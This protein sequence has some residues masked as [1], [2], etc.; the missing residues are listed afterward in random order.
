MHWAKNRGEGAMTE[1]D[2]QESRPHW[3]SK[4]ERGVY[5]GLR[6]MLF[7]YRILGKRV[8][9]VL[10][11]PIIAYF[12]L[13]VPTAREASRTFLNRVYAAPRGQKVFSKKPGLR[14]TFHHFLCFGGSI[15]DSFS[16]WAGLISS[17][18][19]IFEDL[20]RFQ[21]VKEA[22][23]GGV[24][25][26]SHLGNME[27]CRA[28]GQKVLGLKLNVLVHTKHSENF[29]RLMHETNKNSAISVI[30]VTDFGPDTAMMLSNKVSKGEFVV[31]V[32]DRIPVGP[33]ERITFVNFFGKPAPFP[34]GP[35]ILAALLKCPVYSIFCM[36]SEGL[37]NVLFERLAQ[38][39]E[40]P[41]TNREE[42]LE[43]W[44]SRY[45]ERLEDYCL[46]DPYQWYNFFD[47]WSQSNQVTIDNQKSDS[48]H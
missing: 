5:W 32:G 34:Q 12:F 1:A 16:A 20:E 19:I 39:I 47:F 38:S 9:S 3:A 21:K 17:Q 18:D 45:A 33:S 26:S 4:K 25:I 14:Q 35:F 7:I 37:Y 48:T 30:E 28:L 31:I 27:V 42:V 29:N 36:K 44:L 2:K 43:K 10:L 15:L 13:F 6:F 22:G 23:R 41:R 46:R 11:I 24:F 40:M 8:F